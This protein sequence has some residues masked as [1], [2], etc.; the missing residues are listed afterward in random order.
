MEALDLL[1]IP[2]EF[3]TDA[4]ILRGDLQFELGQI[5][6]AAKNYFMVT[7]EHPYHVID[8]QGQLGVVPYT[9]WNG[10]KQRRGLPKWF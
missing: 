8:A 1:S 10:G 2:G 4:Y 5:E 3:S 6:Q 9:V 7:G